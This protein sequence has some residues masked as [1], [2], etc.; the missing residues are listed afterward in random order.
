[1]TL[2]K[3]TDANFNALI[4]SNEK[5]I[6][7]YFADWC[8]TCRLFSPKFTRMAEDSQFEGVTFLDV[9]AEENQEARKLAGVDNLPYFATFKNGVFQEGK[10][11]AKEERI[12]EMIQ[13]L[14]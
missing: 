6:V 1:M 10:A 3:A 5:V 4:S 14:F 9:N 11:T 13:K 8:G 2:I 7:K 12:V